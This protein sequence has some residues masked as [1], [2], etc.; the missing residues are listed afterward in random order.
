MAAPAKSVEEQLE[1]MF[2]SDGEVPGDA[3]ASTAAAT[4]VP[5]D[6]P[7]TNDDA[8][9]RSRGKKRLRNEDKWLRNVRKERRALGQEYVNRKGNLV[10]RK[11]LRKISECTCRYE[12]HKH[13]NEEQQ[14]QVFNEFYNLGSHDL[15]SAFLFTMIKVVDKARSY[16]GQ[17]HSRREKT[18]LYYLLNSNGSET[19][20]CKRFFQNTLAV[21]AGR[22]DRVLKNKGEKATPPR[23]GRGKGEPGNKTPRHK[24]DVVKRFIEKFPAYE[25]HYAYHKN[26]GRKYLGPD[27]NLSVMYSLYCAEEQM[28]VSHFIF[29]KIFYEN[30]NLS[31]H[32]PVSDSCRTC[33]AL[34]VKITAA[35]NDKERTELIAEREFHQQKAEYAR[36]G[37][38]SD[39][40][41]S[42]SDG[43][44]TVI[45]F[46]LMK[47]LPTPIIST[48]VCYYKRQLWT[49]CFGIHNMHN[50]DVY[51]FLWHES[52][53]S[54]GPQ[55]IGSCLLYFIRNF[56]RTE[57]LIMYS[58]QCGGQNRNIKVAVLCQYIV[59][60]SE[61]SVK[62]IDHKFLVSGH[63]YLPCDQDFG[64]VQKR[65]KYFPNIY[66]PKHWNDVV[67]SARK[68]NPFKVI[69]MNAE[70]FFSTK[71]LERNITNRKCLL[72]IVKYNG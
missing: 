41:L 27:L 44:V 15:Q 50:D 28:P 35:D 34:Q 8:V 9:V 10:P 24:V 71:Q 65:K 55:E 31:F 37:L 38:H 46:D 67:V 68:R 49:Y 12:C 53:A 20:V 18:R 63:S 60:S 30:F 57:K 16:V 36:A 2:A 13:I 69:N 14:E 33:D 61:F 25:S 4:T 47:T 59:N 39:T 29:R 66:R 43:N 5:E 40:L 70:C 11:E 58:D 7:E 3:R 64:L 72:A 1:E 45:T 52:I 42:K 56:V 48:G 26:N 32:P 62:E 21:S 17:Q 19:R 54:R 51:M 6:V 23:D 22:I